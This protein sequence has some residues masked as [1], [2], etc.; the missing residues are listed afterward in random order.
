MARDNRDLES[1]YRLE[2]SKRGLQDVDRIHSQQKA[3][4]TE[5]W[6]Y[7]ARKV[8]L[9]ARLGEYLVVPRSMVCREQ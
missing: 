4:L 1:A 2:K 7:D 3:I 5:S 9:E 6:M 8:V